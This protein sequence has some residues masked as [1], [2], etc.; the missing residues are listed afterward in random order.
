M[1]TFLQF[2]EEDTRR[3]FLKKLG[4]GVSGIASGI[5]P[6]KGM[7]SDDDEHDDDD[8]D[9]SEDYYE[10]YFDVFDWINSNVLDHTVIEQS[11]IL[12]YQK[13]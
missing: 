3:D 12:K 11:G 1:Q 13:N 10:D 7:S 2:L 4:M 9:P 6:L 8:Y 5:N